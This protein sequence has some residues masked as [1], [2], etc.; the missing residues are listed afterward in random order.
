MAGS[1]RNSTCAQAHH[2]NRRTGGCRGA[3]PKAAVRIV[4]PALDR[5]AAGQRTGM[6][7]ASRHL[8][9]V[10][11]KADDRNWRV[12]LGRHAP[13][14]KLKEIVFSPATSCARLHDGTGMV[15]TGRQRDGALWN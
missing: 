13:A 8:D 14:A 4:A 7:Q 9:E 1:D 11:A 2:G 6:Q 3:V 5:S 12:D 10:G 15:S